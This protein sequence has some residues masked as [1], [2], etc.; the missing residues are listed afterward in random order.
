VL[1]PFAGTGTTT[2]AA[3][4]VGRHSIG[5]EIDT[6]YFASLRQCLAAEASN[7]FT[8]ASFLTHTGAGRRSG[9]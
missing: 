3:S 2:L 5:V 8:R 9:R 6:H 4:R 7:F 1:D